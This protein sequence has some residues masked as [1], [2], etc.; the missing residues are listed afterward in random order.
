[1]GFIVMRCFEYI[2]E[3]DSCGDEMVFHTGDGTDN[4]RYIHDLNS[5]IKGARFHRSHGKL[6][7]DDCFR[8]RKMKHA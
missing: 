5:A 2:L 3:C 6:L 8:E 1:M 7:C 4:A